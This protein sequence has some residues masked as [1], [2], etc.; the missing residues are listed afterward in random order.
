MT[1][2]EK[3][4]KL[5]AIS[6]Y[7]LEGILELEF[8]NKYIVLGTQKVQ[9]LQS[10]YYDTPKR[11]FAKLGMVFRVRKEPS[12]Y[13]ATIKTEHKNSGGLSERMEYNVDLTTET[14]DFEGFSKIDFIVDIKAI[15]EKEGT[16]EELFCVDVQRR[17]CDLA[18]TE[19]T[20]VEM[21]VDI[22]KI[23]AGD[24]TLPIAELEFELKKG[25]LQDLI[26]FIA[27]LSS[28]VP[29]Y[30]QA[31]SKYFQ[32]CELSGEEITKPRSLQI[33]SIGV[34]QPFKQEL[35][36]AIVLQAGHCLACLKDF[37]D[38]NC[39]K[40]ESEELLSR[41]QLLQNMLVFAKPLL[42]AE[43][44]IHLKVLDVLLKDLFVHKML[45]ELD[46]NWQKIQCK[47]LDFKITNVFTEIIKKQQQIQ[48]EKL[49]DNLNKGIY[50]RNFFALWAWLNHN[51]WQN[52]V[53]T[54]VKDYIIE[55][56]RKIDFSTY[57]KDI[58][59]L[60]CMITLT[61]QSLPKEFSK[62]FKKLSNLLHLMETKQRDQN[63]SKQIFSL[64]KASSGRLIYR[65][66]GI[67]LGWYLQF[68][69]RKEEKL[70][71]T[72]RLV[73]EIKNKILLQSEKTSS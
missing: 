21:A 28:I 27:Q 9:N 2:V 73:Q 64:F 5:V 17:L 32:G 41:I 69:R 43:L 72:I 3:E 71:K 44:D 25:N 36:D 55:E 19:E 13:V 15:V 7:I 46:N 31:K 52:I 50:S 20:V 58:V 66:A 42:Q 61:K 34:E 8:I 14:P 35:L 26:D 29:I 18:L 37:L 49:Q 60:E 10:R 57:T 1:N 45:F 51:P 54:T 33:E 30:S 23:I 24:K 63:I 67:L 6:Q 38:S 56:I 53:E 68:G 12:G 39:H 4:I 11:K 40:K 65:D 70:A 16:V 22:G 59:A 47:Q 48:L 62:F